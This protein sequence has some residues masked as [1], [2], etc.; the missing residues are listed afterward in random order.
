SMSEIDYGPLTGLIGSWKGDKGRDLPPEPDGIED[1]QYTETIHFSAID[2]VDNAETQE[3]A[4][5]HYHL[6]V[7]RIPDGKAIHN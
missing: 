3:L 2:D 6:L 1:N 4:A 7:H 5:M